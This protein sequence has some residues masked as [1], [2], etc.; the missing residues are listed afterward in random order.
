MNL[1]EKKFIFKKKKQL[2]HITNY[3]FNILILQLFQVIEEL[4]CSLV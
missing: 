2:Q 4:Y 1:K 3:Q